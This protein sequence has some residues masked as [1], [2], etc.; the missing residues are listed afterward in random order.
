MSMRRY[1]IL[2]VLALAALAIAAARPPDVSP[3]SPL[4]VRFRLA[5]GIRIAGEMTGWDDKGIEGSFGRRRWVDLK[6]EDAFNLRRRVM[7]KEEA[8]QWVALGRLMLLMDDGANQAARRAEQ[9][10]RV[11]LRL[12]KAVEQ[13]IADARVAVDEEK[14]RLAEEEAREQAGRLRTR[15]PEAGPWKA[16]PWPELTDAEREATVP[17]MKADAEEI[18]HRAG[19][20]LAPIESDHFLIY[21][22]MPREEGARWALRLEDL[23][24]RMLAMFG[25]DE[26]AD[27]F[28]GKAT[29]LVFSEQ[30]RFR[31]VEADAFGQLV[32][33]WVT[34][35]CHFDGPKVFIN[36]HH[37]SDDHAFA[38][39][40]L[41]AAVHG[42]MHRYQTPARL[43]A[44]A[45]EGFAD[46]LASEMLDKSPVFERRRRAGLQYVR[47]GGDVSAVLG[48]DYE[49]DSWLR[50]DSIGCCVGQLMVELMIREHPGRF[51]AWINAIKAGKDWQEALKEDYGVGRAQLVDTFTRYYL[52]ND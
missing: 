34:G 8:G 44:W 36:C 10:F 14:R 13:A 28:W 15:T 3:D 40:L 30:D 26:K 35:L 51:V 7:D 29:V 2:A 20:E 11:A 47:N 39:S 41:R 1:A 6:V 27:I 52:V 45:N 21:S 31:M 25:R 46:H 4:T 5:D 18:L 33:S 50:P 9:A 43:P 12:D 42:F 16:E 38:A 49:S 23:Y 37:G 24:R 48:M 22:D 32:P 17:A 19:L